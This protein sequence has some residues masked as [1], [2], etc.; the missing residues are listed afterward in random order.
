MLKV[1]TL[2]QT[3]AVFSPTDQPNEKPQDSDRE[4]DNADTTKPK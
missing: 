3:P 4:L 1:V 2:T